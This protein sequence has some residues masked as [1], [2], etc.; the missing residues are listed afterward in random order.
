MSPD[1]EVPSIEGTAGKA[2][3]T[4]LIIAVVAVVVAAIGAIVTYSSMFALEQVLLTPDPETGSAVITIM[5]SNSIRFTKANILWGSG[6]VDVGTTAVLNTTGMG[7]VSNSNFAPQT[8][9]G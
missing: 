6:N 8:G 1:M 5:E 2:N 9:F 4:L 7:S 3:N